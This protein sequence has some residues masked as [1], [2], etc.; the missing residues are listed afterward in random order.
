MNML[1]NLLYSTLGRKFLMAL[2]GLALFG[3]VIIHM[4]GN[5]QI[6]LGPDALNE[7]AH[8]LK[9]KAE[10][11]WGFRLGLLGLVAVHIATAVSLARE[12]RAARPVP[13][14]NNVPPAAS[15]ASR[16]MVWSGLIVLSFIIYHLLHFTVGAVDPGYLQLR[17]AHGNHDV[18]RMVV[19][20]FSHPIVSGFYILSV[21]LLCMHLS[22]GVASLFQSLGLKGAAWGPIIDRFA[23]ISAWVIFL[24][25]SSIP[26]AIL[27]GLVH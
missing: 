25:N 1:R 15:Y 23:K 2:S 26:L 8:L 13:Y 11:L 6:F 4:L 10:I 20:G 21:G 14:E 3:F 12:N 27:T 22:H 24:G 17:D 5:L 9:S 7:Y 18:Y 16:T 19:L